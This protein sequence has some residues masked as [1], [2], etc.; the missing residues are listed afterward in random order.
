MIHRKV[1][2]Y[3]GLF[4]FCDNWPHI[5]A[6]VSNSMYLLPLILSFR[7]AKVPTPLESIHPKSTTP[8]FVLGGDRWHR[9]G[10]CHTS[11]TFLQRPDVHPTVKTHF[12][13]L[14]IAKYYSVP[15]PVTSSWQ[16]DLVLHQ[17]RQPNVFCL[18]FESDLLSDNPSVS[19]V[20]RRER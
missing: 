4:Q 7:N 6:A 16:I 3:Q 8:N 2:P 10:R 18:L 19:V 14:F 9:T 20:P 13:L 1:F 11:P 5:F 12:H 15:V 17:A